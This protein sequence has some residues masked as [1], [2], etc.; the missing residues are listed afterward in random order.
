MLVTILLGTFKHT[1]S[2]IFHTKISNYH[3]VKIPTRWLGYLPSRD[4]KIVP[5]NKKIMVFFL[6]LKLRKVFIQIIETKH[7]QMKNK[8]VKINRQ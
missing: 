6:Q 4:L 7:N 2:Y 1:Y 3:G 5:E 8:I